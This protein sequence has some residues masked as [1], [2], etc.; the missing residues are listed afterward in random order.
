MLNPLFGLPRYIS[1]SW[2]IYYLAPTLKSALNLT[3]LW[4][5]VEDNVRGAGGRGG[6]VHGRAHTCVLGPA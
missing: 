5:Y 4:N 3:T 6:G 2:D 1:A